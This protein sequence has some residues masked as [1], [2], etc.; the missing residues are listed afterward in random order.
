[1]NDQFVS[2]DATFTT[3]NK[4]KRRKPAPSME[5]KSSVPKMNQLQTYTINLTATGIGF[6]II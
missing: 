2:E 3:Q 1:M 4:Q 5:F 6:R